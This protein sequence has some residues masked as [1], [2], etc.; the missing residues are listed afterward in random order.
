MGKKKE[1]EIYLQKIINLIM[2]GTGKTINMKG[3]G[4]YLTTVKNIMENSK[5]V[6]LMEKGFYI[7]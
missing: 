1:K 4:P 6:N 7:K 3:R 5:M 2:M